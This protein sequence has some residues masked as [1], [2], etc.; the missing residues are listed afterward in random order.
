MEAAP[1]KLDEKVGQDRRI[2]ANRD[3]PFTLE[4]R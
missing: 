2:A 1:G 4:L 3:I